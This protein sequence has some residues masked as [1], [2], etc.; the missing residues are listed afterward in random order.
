M[1]LQFVLENF[2]NR[3]PVGFECY[4]SE[5]SLSS[6][7]TSTS[8]KLEGSLSTGTSEDGMGSEKMSGNGVVRVGRKKNLI[9]P[10]S[11]P[12]FYSHGPS[13]STDRSDFAT[14][15]LTGDTDTGT[16]SGRGKGTGIVTRNESGSG[17]GVGEIRT[18]ERRGVGREEAGNATLAS[19]STEMAHLAY[20]GTAHHAIT[21]FTTSCTIL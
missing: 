20:A 17:R 21:G 11:H 13:D 14:L 8:T 15:I 1:I 5:S 6:T 2:A 16:E 3:E 19:H 10:H 9:L 4:S 18:G 12:N 7:S